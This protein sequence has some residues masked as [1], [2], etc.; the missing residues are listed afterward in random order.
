[1][2]NKLCNYDSGQPDKIKNINN[3]DVKNNNASN[4][5]NVDY[6]SLRNKIDKNGNKNN[7]GENTGENYKN[8]MKIFFFNN[9]NSSII[10]QKTKINANV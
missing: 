4:I 3:I 1:M 8:M 5:L 6:N 9:K 7:L 2:H 10:H